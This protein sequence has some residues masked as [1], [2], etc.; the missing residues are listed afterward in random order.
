MNQYS[1]S[2]NSNGSRYDRLDNFKLSKK[3]YQ[4]ICKYN[5]IDESVTV[6]FYTDVN[7]PKLIGNILKE[8]KHTIDQIVEVGRDEQ[9]YATQN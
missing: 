5:K 3:D 4:F 2:F 8:I 9:D 6:I 7:N 1:I